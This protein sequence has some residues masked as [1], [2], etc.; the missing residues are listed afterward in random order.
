M[1]TIFRHDCSSLAPFTS[2]LTNG[3]VAVVPGG[4]GINTTP[5]IECLKNSSNASNTLGIYTTT[6]SVMQA[7]F[8]WY[9]QYRQ[10]VNQISTISHIHSR[11][12]PG[13]CFTGGGVA[14]MFDV[15]DAADF[16]LPNNEGFI[17]VQNGG[18]AGSRTPVGPKL[19]LNLDWWDL[20]CLCRPSDGFMEYS[21]R[22]SDTPGAFDETTPG[23]FV[24][25]GT[26]NATS[27]DWRGQNIHIAFDAR[28]GFDILR[29]DEVILT[30]DGVTDKVAAAVDEDGIPVGARWVKSGEG[31]LRGLRNPPIIGGPRPRG[32]KPRG[33]IG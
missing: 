21:V 1:S 13:I 23:V 9:A 20:R 15:A 6:A 25:V 10:T 24:Q 2:V 11:K 17:G 19:L 22:P 32:F 3:T 4:D 14:S 29:V 7:G 8:V 30:D 18:S 5:F 26:M 12:L 16:P 27:G 28:R 33:G 31:G